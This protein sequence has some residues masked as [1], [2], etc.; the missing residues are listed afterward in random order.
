MAA[1]MLG[2]RRRSCR[3]V[4]SRRMVSK[5]IPSVLMDASH[6]IREARARSGF[7][8]R[9]LAER[10]GTSHSTI[11]AYE[12][13]RMSP[14]VATLNRIVRA[15]GFALDGLLERRIYGESD[16]RG[17]ELESVL[18]LAAAFPARHSPSGPGQVFGRQSGQ[19]FPS[20]PPDPR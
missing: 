16:D 5:P 10:A 19:S 12:T 15:A 3:K 17:T 1:A 6:V 13:G 8:L 2:H 11:S 7:T 14:T 9:A 20:E 18:T 4:V